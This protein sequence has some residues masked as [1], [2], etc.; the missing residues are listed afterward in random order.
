MQMRR[1]EHTDTLAHRSPQEA[2]G[3][4][5]SPYSAAESP[6][7]QITG[8]ASEPFHLR[9]FRLHRLWCVVGDVYQADIEI[10]V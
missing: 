3:W 6:L 5:F 2:R 8:R 10:V 1:R 4:E 9:N 7:W